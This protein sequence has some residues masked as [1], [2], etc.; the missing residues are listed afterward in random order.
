MTGN[1]DVLLLAY[2]LILVGATTG[3][4]MLYFFAVLRQPMR[5]ASK[6]VA[7]QR[8]LSAG[9]IFSIAGVLALAVMAA[10]VLSGAAGTDLT[11]FMIATVIVPPAVL[12]LN[13]RGQRT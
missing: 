10:E 8:L 1:A 4:Q 11:A 12:W 2:T 7:A 5:F 13:A 6:T 3:A 9:L